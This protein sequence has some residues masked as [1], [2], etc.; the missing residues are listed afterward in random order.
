MRSRA[1]GLREDVTVRASAPAIA[2]GIAIAGVWSSERVEPTP[3][4]WQSCAGLTDADMARVAGGGIVANR[5]RRRNIARPLWLAAF[6]STC[7]LSSSSSASTT[8]WGSNAVRWSC[9]LAGSATRRPWRT[10]QGLTSIHRISTRSGDAAS[11]TAR[12]APGRDDRTISHRR[13]LDVG[14]WRDQAT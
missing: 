5:C 8:S 7:P 12:E 10:S 14:D 2:L 6:A 3:P 4:L 1:A 13:G 11:A 9:R